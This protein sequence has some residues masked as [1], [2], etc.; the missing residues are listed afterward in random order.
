MKI[1]QWFELLYEFFFPRFVTH[2][3]KVVKK[4]NPPEDEYIDGLGLIIRKMLVGE[5]AEVHHKYFN[6]F[7]MPLFE[8]YE[9]IG[10]KGIKADV[11]EQD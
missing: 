10:I 6:F 5:E 3:L 1:V 8:S 2:K 7:G 4:G 9:L 11:Y